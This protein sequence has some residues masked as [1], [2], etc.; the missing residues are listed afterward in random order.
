MYEKENLYSNMLNSTKELTLCHMLPV[1]VVVVGFVCTISMKEL[2][3]GQAGL[4]N[5]GMAAGLRERKL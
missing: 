1:V 2:L 3:V 5:L 4:F